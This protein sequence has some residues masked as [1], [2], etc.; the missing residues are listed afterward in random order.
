M[1]SAAPALIALLVAVIALAVALFRAPEPP[2]L[3]QAPVTAGASAEEALVQ[4][5]ASLEAEVAKLGGEIAVLRSSSPGTR[6]TM[7]TAEV[8]AEALAAEVAQLERQLAEQRSTRRATTTPANVSVRE[9]EVL[10]AGPKKGIEDWVR[11]V[12][13]G[14]LTEEEML[15]ALRSLR[16]ARSSNGTDPRLGVLPE[17]IRLA[18]SSQDESARAD[19]WRQLSG[20]TDPSLLQP[21]LRA[22]QSDPSAKVREEAA[23]TLGDF[24]PDANARDALQFAA[25][26][27][28]SPD[29]RA[30]CYESLGSRRR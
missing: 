9:A 22:L 14:A 21:L 1:K 30:Q 20:V 10:D 6:E 23:E 4:R 26:N 8:D 16:G 7:A 13:S 25:E 17:M 18:E 12:K 27:D 5:I 19:V 3:A 24:L 15:T 28:A 29:V 11:R 2:I